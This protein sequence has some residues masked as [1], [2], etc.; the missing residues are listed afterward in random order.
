MDIIGWHSR[1]I[2]RW[3]PPWES[4]TIFVP[5]TGKRDTRLPPRYIPVPPHGNIACYRTLSITNIS[6]VESGLSSRRRDHRQHI[7]LN[8]ILIHGPL[9]SRPLESE[10]WDMS[11]SYRSTINEGAN[12]D[13]W[14]IQ[15]WLSPLE[16]YG[17]HQDVSNGRLDG[18]GDWV[19]Q[20]NQFRTWCKSQICSVNPTLLCCGGKGVGKTYIR[21]GSIF[22]K[23]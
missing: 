21:Y 20:K 2:T 6:P 18:V 8:R 13:P 9:Y 5:L 11:N 1:T 3:Y 19:L 22:Q 14:R 7:I 15:A 4:R 23:Q 17:R 16:P 10:H 12:E